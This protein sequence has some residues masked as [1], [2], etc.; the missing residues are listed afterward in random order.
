[1]KYLILIS[2]VISMCMAVPAAAK[3]PSLPPVPE[4]IPEPDQSRLKKQYD[5]AFQFKEKLNTRIRAMNAK[6]TNIPEDTPKVTECREEDASIS[7]EKTKYSGLKSD[8]LRALS[9]AGG[10][11]KKK[12]DPASEKMIAS[13][14]KYSAQQG[15]SKEEQSRL[16]ESLRIVTLE[17]TKIGSRLEVANIWKAMRSRGPDSAPAR[18]AAAGK[19]PGLHGAGK[20][21]HQ[22][23]TIFALSNGAGLPYGV[24][25]ARAAEMLKKAEWR[26]ATERKNPQ[27]TIENQGILAGE[28]AILAE[29]FGHA[30]VIPPSGFAKALEDGRP[31]I[32]GVQM[33]GGGHEV[34]L[35]KSFQHEG[36]T[37]YEMMESNQEPDLRLY[38]SARQLDGILLDNGII[39]HPDPGTTPQLLRKGE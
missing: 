30:E 17:K 35:S 15:W 38:L 36:E 1:M 29:A 32:T 23:C 6:C 3:E 25:A 5:E 11:M 16:D 19:G 21:S 31:V 27:A 22:D 37:W 33:P 26:P 28:V 8:Y 13:M 18:A 39:F 9:G 12:L 20:Q 24:T 4:N 2:F 10:V 34:V 7:A 14:I